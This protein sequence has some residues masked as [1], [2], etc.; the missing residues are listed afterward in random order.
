MIP[1]KNS[2]Q[3]RRALAGVALIAAMVLALYAYMGT[4]IYRPFQFS[5]ANGD[6]Y[7]LL[8]DGF[9]HGSLALAA[10]PPAALAQLSDPYDP[11]QREKAGIEVKHDVSY[12]HGRYYLYFGVAPAVTF[13]WPFRVL[14]GVHFPQS[15]ATVLFCAGGYLC[16]LAL[17]LSLRR[18]YFSGTRTVWLWL[19]S[20]MLGLANFC[21]GMLARNSIWE[22]PIACAYFYSSLGLLLLFHSYHA[23]HS[24]AL[25]LAATGT[26]CGL[27]IASRP[28]FLLFC[29][30]LG[31][32]WLCD[33]LRSFRS[34]AAS[35]RAD[36]IR[37]TVALF[38]CP[39]P[40][41]SP[42]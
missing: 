36:W 24:R 30:A 7:P 16:N 4:D 5:K 8:V 25:W 11:V 6:Y 1:L 13:F 26:A 38:F 9:R 3:E 14:T 15:L 20:L 33:R 34:E 28:H 39:S 23:K 32:W 37:E 18:R 27:S 19:G 41:S 40:S 2:R 42:D 17:V 22:V 12:Y 21:P 29:V 10:E 31:I 35:P